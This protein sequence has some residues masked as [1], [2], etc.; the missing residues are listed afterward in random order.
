MRWDWAGPC[1][2]GRFH[3]A[4]MGSLEQLESTRPILGL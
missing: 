3:G 1:Q 2:V 4:E